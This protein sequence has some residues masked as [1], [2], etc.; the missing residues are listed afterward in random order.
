MARIPIALQ[1]YT[2]RETLAKDVKGTIKAVADMG[3]EGAEGGV[4]AGW[5]PGDWRKLI[6][7]HGMKFV[8]SG[9]GAGDLKSN[10]PALVAKCAQ[11]GAKTVMFGVNQKDFKDAGDDWKKVVADVKPA[12]EKAAAAGLRILYHN[13]DHEFRN[14]VDG[15]YLLDYIYSTIGADVLKAEID[16]YWV[17]TG[18][19]DPVKYIRKYAGRVPYLHIKDRERDAPADERRAFTEIGNG[20]LDWDAIFAE[21]PKAGVE[22]YIV[23]QDLTKRTPLESAKISVDYLKSRGMA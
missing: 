6:E 13:H 21:A 22:W 11:L 23:E 20:S 5:T 2:V 12:V 18:G 17:A 1:L 3:Y 10:L 14:K 16:T 9:G 4:P 15:M 8:G 19:E 7:D